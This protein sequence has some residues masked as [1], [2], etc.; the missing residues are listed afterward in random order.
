MRLALV[1]QVHQ[2]ALDAPQIG[3]PTPRLIE[4]RRCDA[5]DTAAVGAVIPAVGARSAPRLRHQL[6]PLVI[7]HG[8]HPDARGLGHVADRKACIIHSR[9]LSPY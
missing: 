2:H 7:T 3:N 8:F 5:P 6:P 9:R 4:P 1:K